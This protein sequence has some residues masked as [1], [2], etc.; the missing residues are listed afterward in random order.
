MK[1]DSEFVK[2]FEKDYPEQ[3]KGDENRQWSTEMSLDFSQQKLTFKAI[4][5]SIISGY[6][7][8]IKQ[9]KPN[10]LMIDIVLK[11]VSI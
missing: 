4:Q 9:T 2:K 3:V 1:I 5:K 6:C 10:Q 7:D 8:W 11:D